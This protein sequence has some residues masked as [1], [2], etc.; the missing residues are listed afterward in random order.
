MRK[1]ITVVAVAVLICA[2]VVAAQRATFIPVSGIAFLIAPPSGGTVRCNGGEPAPGWPPCTPGSKTQ[3][4]GLVLTYRTIAYK[5]DG[6]RDPLFTGTRTLVFNYEH[7]VD[8]HDSRVWGT[9]RVVLDGDAGVWEG[10]FSGSLAGTVIG[11][12]TEG[13]VEGMHFV[14]SY[15]HPGAFPPTPG[16][17]E[18]F[19]GYVIDTN[20]KN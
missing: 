2:A 20:A 10:T 3:V 17:P 5:A 16:S 4:R 8:G 12:G 9:F 7:V 13:V 11:H 6:S 18:Q 15:S 19:S 14:G 1:R